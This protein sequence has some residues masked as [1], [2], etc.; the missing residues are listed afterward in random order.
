M[1]DLDS[2]PPMGDAATT[3]TGNGAKG[4][5]C[6]RH[7]WGLDGNRGVACIRCGHHRDDAKVR[8]GK[9][10]RRRGNDMERAVAAAL[11]GTRVGQY[12]TLV[13]VVAGP[14]DIQVKCG[15]RFPGWI[16]DILD[17]MPVSMTR[18]RVLAVFDS[19]GPG[20]KR[21]GLV[22]YLWDDWSDEHGS[23]AE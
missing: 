9:T 14:F 10:S 21:R 3:A 17:G 7:T 13:D 20:T 11:G 19:P 16:A 4:R 23:V 6:V 1:T 12:G 15:G 18:Q 5:K 8:R 22:C 2:L